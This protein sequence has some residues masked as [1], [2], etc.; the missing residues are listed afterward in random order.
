MARE[1]VRRKFDRPPPSND[2]L[3][4]RLVDILECLLGGG[5]EWLG[6]FDAQPVEHPAGDRRLAGFIAQEPVFERGL[7]I[8]RTGLFDGGEL[9]AGGLALADLEQR[10]GVVLAEVDVLRTGLQT[11]L[12]RGYGVIVILGLQEYVGVLGLEVECYREE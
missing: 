11:S 4:Q 6:G 3:L 7:P 1:I 9:V 2:P 8:G 12:K 10:V 5:A